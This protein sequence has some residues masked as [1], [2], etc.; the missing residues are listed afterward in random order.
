MVCM[1][2]LFGKTVIN[3]HV[4]YVGCVRTVMCDDAIFCREDLLFVLV[5]TLTPSVLF[6]RC[7]GWTKSASYFCFTPQ[8]IIVTSVPGLLVCFLPKE[9]RRTKV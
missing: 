4:T 6:P 8:I 2:C 1:L 7:I 3:M 9:E 5:I